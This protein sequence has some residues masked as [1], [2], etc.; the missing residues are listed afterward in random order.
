MRKQVYST[1]HGLDVRTLR[2]F[3]SVVAFK[4]LTLAA[5]A[6]HLA[7]GAASR[8][9]KKFEEL[10]GAT[11]LTRHH[12]GLTLTRIGVMVAESVREILDQFNALGSISN[13]LRIGLTNNV[14][15]VANGV[16]ITEY[17]PDTLRRFRE[18]HPDVMVEIEEA[19]SVNIVSMLIQGQVN[20]GITS[21]YEGAPQLGRIDF[22]REPLVL[23]AP[24]NHPLSRRRR[25]RFTDT[26]D[27]DYI[28]LRTESRIY[29]F[30]YAE[31]RKVAKRIRVLA[32]VTGYYHACCMVSVGLGLAVVPLSTVYSLRELFDL[33]IINLEGKQFSF[34][35][36]VIHVEESKLTAIE[37]ALLDHLR[38]CP[39][40]LAG[41]ESIRRN[42]G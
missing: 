8:R 42:A 6:N 4:S 26:L 9:I 23:V 36:S 5:Q 2:L 30:L 41:P 34:G 35:E 11:L 18:K 27:Y 7:I 20:I 37:R 13:N 1:L 38:D 22:P 24:K 12:R 33:A 16:A 28:A 32:Q 15:I 21:N 19:R 40:M 10:I 14:R 25:V 39:S 29:K 3:E 17:L 31:A